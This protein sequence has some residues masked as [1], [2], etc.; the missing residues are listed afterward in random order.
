MAVSTDT[1]P[2]VNI[3][4]ARAAYMVWINDYTKAQSGRFTAEVVPGIFIL[5]E[6]LLRGVRLGTIDCF[7][8]TAIEFTKLAD[9]AD[10]EHLVLQD[11]LTDGIDYLL[12]VHNSS[13][14]RRI[15]DARGTVILWHRHRDTVL[16]PA[17]IDTLLAANNLPRSEQFFKSSSSQ[18]SLNQVVLPVFFHRADAACVTRRSWET[19]VELNPQI[20]RDLR[21]L[22]VSPRVIP[23]AIGFRRDCNANALSLLLD[24]MLHFTDT[25][26]GRQMAALYQTNRF[27]ERP[28]S[29]MKG[30][31][32]MVRQYERLSASQAGSRKG[33]S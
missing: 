11:Y 12:L 6:E 22:E 19:A 13:Q 30:T 21:I 16:I 3:N 28:V 2:G 33:H 7:G 8:V 10:P 17:W 9:L 29:V 26:S 24:S 1:L 14:F 27:I 25:P 18:D 4:D 31:L 20:G 32:D 5:S 23:T 15:A